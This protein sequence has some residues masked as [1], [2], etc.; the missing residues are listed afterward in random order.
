MPTTISLIAP[1]LI[2]LVASH[3]N[4]AQGVLLKPTRWPLTNTV[5]MSALF[6]NRNTNDRPAKSIG[7]RTLVRY[8]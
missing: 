4:A 7:T 6:G 8:K 3:S 5:E 1:G 2:A